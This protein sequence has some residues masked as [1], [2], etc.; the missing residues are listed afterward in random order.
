MI[1]IA[2][3]LLPPAG[4]ETQ[5]LESSHNG[6]RPAESDEPDSDLQKAGERPFVVPASGSNAPSGPPYRL[7]GFIA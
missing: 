4:S 7:P 5:G 1:I 2:Q 3:R 6:R